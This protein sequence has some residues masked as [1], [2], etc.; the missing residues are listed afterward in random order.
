MAILYGASLF[1][2][3]DAEQRFAYDAIGKNSEVFAIGDPVTIASGVLKVCGAT[4]AP[5]GISVKAQTMASTNQTVAKVAPGYIPIELNDLY[6]M[7]SNGDFA[8]NATDPGTFYKLTGTTG[9]VL[10]DQAS[11]VQTTTSR[12]VEI[13]QVDPFNIGGSGSG[14]GVRQ[15]VV[16]FVRT[17]TLNA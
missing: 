15:V 2:S 6:I 14:S 11:G 5:A 9:A 12:V 17:T 13:V 7:G 16:R 8:G 4:D 3:D 1:R 10:V